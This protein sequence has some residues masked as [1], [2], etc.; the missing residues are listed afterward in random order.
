MVLLLL[1]LLVVLLPSTLYACFGGL[2]GLGGCGMGCGGLG[3][4]G[5]GGG[6]GGLGGGIWPPT[7]GYGAG[8]AAPFLGGAYPAMGAYPILDYSNT[9][10]AYAAASPAAVCCSPMSGYGGSP[11]GRRRK[12]TLPSLIIAASPQSRFITRPTTPTTTT[13]LPSELDLGSW[14]FAD[15]PSS[16]AEKGGEE[17]SLGKD[18]VGDLDY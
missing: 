17:N 11:F 3:L 9:F 6:F 16:W 10:A 4:G 1:F 18:V 2:G 8:Y 14:Q 15:V 13:Q 7:L 5:C 12:R